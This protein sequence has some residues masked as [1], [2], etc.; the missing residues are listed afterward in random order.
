MFKIFIAKLKDNH[1]FWWLKIIGVTLGLVIVGQ[2]AV[3]QSEPT[4]AASTISRSEALKRLPIGCRAGWKNPYIENPQWTDFFRKLRTGEICSIWFINKIILIENKQCCCQYW[5]K[6]PIPE[7]VACTEKKKVERER[8]KEEWIDKFNKWRDQAIKNCNGSTNCIKKIGEPAEKKCVT[9][10]P[11]FGLLPEKTVCSW[12]GSCPD[13][14]TNWLI[15]ESILISI[16]PFTPREPI[17]TCPWSIE[18]YVSYQMR[19]FDCSK[20]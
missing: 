8:L 20:K 19:N 5:F 3:V 2:I 13:G 17:L 11:L 6:C 14:Y 1:P 12:T 10:K 18:E 16:S 15:Y 7:D 9:Y 4:F